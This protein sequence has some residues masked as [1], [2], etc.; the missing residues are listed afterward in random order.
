MACIQNFF[1]YIHDNWR[2]IFDPSFMKGII[3]GA[4]FI[5]LVLILMKIIHLIF[6]SKN[7]RCNGISVKNEDGEVF[8]S[9]GAISDLIKSIEPEFIGVVI[10]KSLLFKQG[11]SY[12]IKLIAELSDKDANFPNVV[13]SIRNKIQFAIKNNLGVEC[14]DKIDIHLKR[15]KG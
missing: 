7:I 14:I 13:G 4:I 10:L 3:V 6:R 12:Y 15:V 11:K 1:S 8:V 2:I 9:S 5:L